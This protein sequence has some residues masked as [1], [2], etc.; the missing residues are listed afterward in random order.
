[1]KPTSLHAPLADA[2][3]A[4]QCCWLRKNDS[5]AALA[6]T[7]SH[8]HTLRP[9]LHQQ[10]STPEAAREVYEGFLKVFPT[11]ASE[12]REYALLEIK[13]KSVGQRTAGPRA[14]HWRLPHSTH[15]GP[16]PCCS[17]RNFKEAEAIFTRCLMDCPHLALWTEYINYLKKADKSR[18]EI[19]RPR[20][21]CAL[22]CPGRRC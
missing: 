11:A 22:L 2:A 4:H 15:P 20:P 5:A 3:I 17:T 7:D 21:P 6:R 13:F 18:S 14:S 16:P 9:A 10:R 12:W 1:M 8:T 19:V